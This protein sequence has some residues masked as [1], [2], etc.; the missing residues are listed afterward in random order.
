MLVKFNF[1]IRNFKIVMKKSF[2]I[3]YIMFLAWLYCS[4]NNSTSKIAS[5]SSN[6]IDSTK[7]VKD[8]TINC[9]LAKRG[10]NMDSMKPFAEVEKYIEFLER[11]DRA[12]WQKPDT[13]ILSMGLKGTETIADVGAGS[14]YFSFRFADKLPKGK[15]IAI[16]IEPEM[17]RHIHHKVMS[18]NIKNIE[19]VL[20]SADD[21]KV[22]ENVNVVF[23]CDVLHHLK[24]RTKWLTRLYSE[25][26]SGTRL[27]LIE[28]KEGNLPEGPPEKIKISAKEMQFTL[29]SVGFVFLRKD[30]ALLPYQNY[31]E[32]TKK[33]IE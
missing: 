1:T 19:V 6:T 13:V 7:K 33:Q 25:L 32:F 23:I 24:D 15:V 14:G 9:P 3:V 16:D 8:V 27:I 29:S 11:S 2:Q 28:F 18:S 12:I 31:F 26:K 22:P 20:A 5:N 21:P 10:M 4:C 30:T 17:V